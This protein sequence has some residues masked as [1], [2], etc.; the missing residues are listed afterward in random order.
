[1]IKLTPEEIDAAIEKFAGGVEWSEAD[2]LSGVSFARAI[3]AEVL[4]I[5][6]WQPIETAPRDGTSVLIYMPEA[7]RKKVM[8][9]YWATPWEGAPEDQCW[10]STPHGP[11]GRGYTILPKAVTHWMRLPAAPGDHI[12]DSSKSFK[13]VT[14]QEA[15]YDRCQKHLREAGKAYPRT[16]SVCGLW[17]PCQFEPQTH[18]ALEALANTFHEGRAG[19][20]SPGAEG[21]VSAALQAAEDALAPPPRATGCP[22]T[23]DDTGHFAEVDMPAFLKRQAPG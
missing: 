17:G 1:M 5:Y 12:A 10:W 2:Y 9:A 21:Y 14:I 23:M 19:C 13:P 18:R 16:C 6:G 3:E 7:S 20:V 4:R 11:A 22:D 15:P 8:E